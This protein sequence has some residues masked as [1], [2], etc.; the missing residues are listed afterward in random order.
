MGPDQPQLRSIQNK[1]YSLDSLWGGRVCCL[2]YLHLLNLSSRPTHT[3]FDLLRLGLLS[4]GSPHFLW[5][6][7]PAPARPASNDF[8]GMALPL[9]T[10]SQN[11][12]SKT[13][14]KLGLQLTQTT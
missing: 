9:A 7:L 13:C 11:Q 3:C 1:A 12:P 6:L 14:S 4:G 5:P 2:P 10:E 8:L